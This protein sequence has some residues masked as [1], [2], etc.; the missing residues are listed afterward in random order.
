MLRLVCEDLHPAGLDD[1][2][3]FPGVVQRHLERL[4]STW[5]GVCRL[6]IIATPVPL[7]GDVRRELFRIVREALN[8]AIKHSNAT[9]IIVR[10]WYPT[11][12]CE[13]VQ[14]R[15]RDN[16]RGTP[17]GCT[18]SGGLGMY[19]MRASAQ[20]IGGTF[21]VHA[22]PGGGIEIAVA[23]HPLGRTRAARDGDDCVTKGIDV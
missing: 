12:D 11:P 18:R 4:Q 6:D 2:A 15:I 13:Q 14:V 16:G 8:N 7:A 17:A 23:A 1:P 3:G 9:E 19:Y 10:L 22:A 5:R 20:A 21:A